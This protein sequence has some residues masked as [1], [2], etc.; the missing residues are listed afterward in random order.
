MTD[1]IEVGAA[2]ECSDYPLG[3]VERGGKVRLHKKP[4]A[5]PSKPPAADNTN[6]SARNW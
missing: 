1:Q 5:A 6:V 4:N 3:A 2:V